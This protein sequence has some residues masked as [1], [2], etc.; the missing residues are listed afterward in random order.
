MW[1]SHAA[2]RFVVSPALVQRCKSASLVRWIAQTTVPHRTS[3][4]QPLL[5]AT[6]VAAGTAVVPAHRPN[7]NCPNPS[8]VIAAEGDGPTLKLI[9]HYLPAILGQ[10]IRCATVSKSPP[11]KKRAHAL[12]DRNFKMSRSCLWFLIPFNALQSRAQPGSR[13]YRDT[14]NATARLTPTTHTFNSTN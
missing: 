9:W 4:H 5:H 6:P 12:A 1:F 8:A 10:A 13:I 14:T 11:A 3:T 7:C 2:S